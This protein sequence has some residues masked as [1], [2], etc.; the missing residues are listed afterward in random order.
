M[1][2]LPVRECWKHDKRHRSSTP[3]ANAAYSGCCGTFVNVMALGESDRHFTTQRATV[4]MNFQTVPKVPDR[5]L[6]YMR[7]EEKGRGR[8]DENA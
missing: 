1:Y 8:D 7:A 5:P 2:S 4:K 6:L 3:V